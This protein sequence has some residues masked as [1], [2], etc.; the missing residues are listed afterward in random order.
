MGTTNERAQDV[1]PRYWSSLKS[2]VHP[3][4]EPVFAQTGS[5]GFNLDFPPPAFIG[6][7]ANAP[8]LILDNNGGYDAT[9][10]GEF[11]D[12]QAQTEF[13]GRLQSSSPVDPKARGVSPYYLRRNFSHWLIDGR[14]ALVNAVAYRSVDGKAPDVGRLAKLLHSAR[15]HREWL[16]NVVAPSAARGERFV[17]VHRWSLWGAAV[18][19][20]R[21]MPGAVFSPAPV[22]KDLSALEMTAVQTFLAKR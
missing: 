13:R 7:V 15:V 20:L 8:V 16:Q 2:T 1:L 9:T 22:S 11:P 12:G 3:D 6:D 10:P 5:H 19:G 14:V 4:D 21:G 17:V 18:N